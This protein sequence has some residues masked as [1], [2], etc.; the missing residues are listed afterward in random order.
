MIQCGYISSACFVGGGGGGIS[1]R[2]TRQ[3]LFALCF[4]GLGD[5]VCHSNGYYGR[6]RRKC[7]DVGWRA[8][9]P[10]GISLYPKNS[11][12]NGWNVE[13]RK[14]ISNVAY[15]YYHLESP[16]AFSIIY[17]PNQL[18]NPYCNCK[19]TYS[20]HKQTHSI[21]LLQNLFYSDMSWLRQDGPAL[22]RGFQTEGRVFFFVFWGVGGRVAVDLCQ[23]LVVYF[24]FG[25]EV[26]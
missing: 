18:N 26:G 21:I 9:F 25:G 4:A 19:T 13:A 11:P 7:G 6:Q 23:G 20:P 10:G 14:L 22:R 24:W 2:L 16:C 8:A 1:F 3:T 15:T 12:D 5:L 17:Q